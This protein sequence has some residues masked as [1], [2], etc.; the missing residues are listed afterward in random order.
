MSVSETAEGHW[1]FRQAL[2]TYYRGRYQD[3][4][5]CLADIIKILECN[6]PET[7][8]IKDILDRLVKHYSERVVG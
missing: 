8:Q 2:V 5:D 4:E 1:R 6:V 7:T 3:G